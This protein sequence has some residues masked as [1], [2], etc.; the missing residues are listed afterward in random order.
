M[1][2]AIDEF[3]GRDDQKWVDWF[4]STEEDSVAN[5]AA[6]YLYRI[7]TCHIVPYFEFGNL[8][9]NV[10]TPDAIIKLSNHADELKSKAFQSVLDRLHAAIGYLKQLNRIDAYDESGSLINY[11]T[12]SYYDSGILHEVLSRDIDQG[13]CVFE[14]QTTYTYMEDNKL[15]SRITV[16][17]E[18][19]DESSGVEYTYDTQ[20]RLIRSEAWEGGGVATTYEYDAQNRLIRATEES[21]V[22]TAE[23][24]YR[25]DENGRLIHEDRTSSEEET[26]ETWTDTTVYSYDTEGRLSR[27]EMKGAYQTVIE[28]YDYTY[29]PFVIVDHCYDGG[30]HSFYVMLQDGSLEMQR[31]AVFDAPL[32]YTDADGYLAKVIDQEDY[33]GTR[34]YEFSY[35]GKVADPENGPFQMDSA[36]V[37]QSSSQSTTTPQ[38]T[39][40]KMD[41]LGNWYSETAN[42]AYIFTSTGNNW[43]VTGSGIQNVSGEY[44][45]IDLYDRDTE[46]GGFDL[47]TDSTITFYRPKS[48]TKSISLNGDTLSMDG[49]VYKKAPSTITSQVLGRWN[50][51]NLFVQFDGKKCTENT[52]GELRSESYYVLSDSLFVVWRS[53]S[54]RVREYSINGTTM[55]YQYNTYHKDGADSSAS[56]LENLATAVVG[57]WRDDSYCEYFIYANGTYERYFNLYSSRG[58]LELHNLEEQGTY[59]ILD[60]EKIRLWVNGENVMYDDFI[61]NPQDDTLYMKYSDRTLTRFQ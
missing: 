21:E 2:K 40:S 26:D 37:L 8:E 25:Y 33:L 4:S 15:Q 19:P 5:Y 14:L 39:T 34:I 51:G 49:H 47:G 61:Y 43:S 44:I 48:D 50:C 36:E 27:K 60:H 53:G 54:Y 29:L 30:K 55:T 20:G 42:K 57:T 1:A 46:F 6:E 22:G 3:G 38:S 56:T 9:D 58:E 23:I 10:L 12:Y 11:S 31:V 13:A 18:Y 24:E 35:D 52:D 45:E 17:P 59:E 32:F 41:L 7:T 16:N 28:E